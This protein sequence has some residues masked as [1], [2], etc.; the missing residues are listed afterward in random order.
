M[1]C[2]LFLGM[3]VLSNSKV[4]SIQSRKWKLHK[5]RG[6]LFNTTLFPHIFPTQRVA[7][8][9]ALCKKNIKKNEETSRP[10][11]F[12]YST[13]AKF[14]VI[15]EIVVVCK[16]QQWCEIIFQLCPIFFFIEKMPLHSSFLSSWKVINAYNLEY[17][18]LL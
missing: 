1:I 15:Y 3:F 4:N 7:M 6:F 14:I 9:M 8:I 10:L 12:D 11:L 17:K 5:S 2:I 18:I 13:L 16:N